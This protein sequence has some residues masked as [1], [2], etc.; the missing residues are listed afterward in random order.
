MHEY[1]TADIYQH[2]TSV[3]NNNLNPLTFHQITKLQDAYQDVGKVLIV[4]TP[5]YVSHKCLQYI[6]EE[7][8][9][10]SP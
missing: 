9:I 1:H 4:S 10:S 5:I 6:E 7:P 2:S 3:R 8:N